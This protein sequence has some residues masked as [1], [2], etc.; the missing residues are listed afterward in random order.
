MLKIIMVL[1]FILSFF[2][3]E[4]LAVECNETF[5]KKV[6]VD[7]VMTQVQ[8]DAFIEKMCVHKKIK[9]SGFVTD[10][11]P[12]KISL[13]DEFGTK[14]RADLLNSEAC[15][16]LVDI[17]KGDKLVIEAIIRKIFYGAH[18]IKAKKAVCVE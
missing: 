8:K 15:G 3:I 17:N 2:S 1:A 6:L 12:L 4:V 7:K 10:V 18:F 16:K 13:K 14:Y 5:I 11:E 9:V